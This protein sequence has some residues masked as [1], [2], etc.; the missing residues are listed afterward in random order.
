MFNILNYIVIKDI[1]IDWSSIV[2]TQWMQIWQKVKKRKLYVTHKT[3]S[4][5]SGWW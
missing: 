2:N 1:Q 3:N 4:Y 5:V